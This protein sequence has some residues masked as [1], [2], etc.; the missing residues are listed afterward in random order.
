[1]KN[2][3]ILTAERYFA[4]ISWSF[5]DKNVAKGCQSG[6]QARNVLECPPPKRIIKKLKGNNI[7]RSAI[8]YKGLSNRLKWSCLILFARVPP[9]CKESVI[10]E[11]F[12]N[13][14]YVKF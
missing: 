11:K 14:I 1:M 2:L 6:N 7:S 4:D 12:E 8:A 9:G 13:E 3:K 10:R 5:A